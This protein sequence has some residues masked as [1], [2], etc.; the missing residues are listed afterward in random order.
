M[1]AALSF[2]DYTVIIVYLAGMILLGWWLSRRQKSDEEYFL[3][4]RG[5]PW[6]AVGV[7]VI[8]S[9]LSSLTYLSEPG[10][11]WNSGVTHVFGKMIAIPIEMLIVFFICI[12]FMMRFRFT[13][14]YEYLEHRFDYA[15][16]LLGVGLFMLM[17]VLWMG[18]VV[19]VSSKAL[20]RVAEVDVFYIIVTVGLI[21]TIYTTLG[22]LRAVIWTDVIQV[23][24][25]IGG[26]MFTI[27]FVM[28]TTGTWLP[29]W[30]AAASR[31]LVDPAV[32]QAATDAGQ[33][34]PHAVE[35]ISFSPFTR[36]TVVTAAISMCVWHVCT[37]SAN[38]M[39]VQRY[40]STSDLKT[41]RRSFVTASV[42]S[43]GLNLMLVAVGLAVLFYYYGD[44]D[45]DTTN[46]AVAA[47]GEPASPYK[48]LKNLNP[49][50]KKER[51]LIFTTFAVNRL[52][53]GLGGAVL[54]ALLAAAM[55]SID[56]GINSIATV[57]TVERKRNQKEGSQKSHVTQ[58]KIITVVAG[59]FITG[60]AYALNFLPNEWGIIDS[61]PR[62]FNAVTGPIG[63]LFMIGIFVPKATGRVAI[64]AT[65]LGLLTSIM[66]GYYAIFAGNLVDAGF[67]STEWLKSLGLATGEGK[68]R[69]LSPMLPLPC[70]LA[71]TVGSAWI[72]SWISAAQ[73]KDLAGLTWYTRHE[74]S[75]LTSDW[76]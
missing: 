29:D 23:A 39:T 40:Y 69:S 37:H 75:E 5:M 13:S 18:F 38:Q 46:V 67:L 47:N 68:V 59:V 74:K 64:M 73:T 31:H 51:D 27:F 54:A 76:Q 9:L 42:F 41:A 34:P 66:I 70:A 16:R 28:Y 60:A 72:L 49:S 1:L 8:A 35:F 20:A 21:A 44:V 43:V 2:L 24:L 53:M 25:L 7:S 52:P 11:V 6:F 65:M 10:E 71:M 32:H 14:A 57:I 12:P 19:L 33:T 4:G 45:R 26:G 15:T 48:E 62:T 36:V 61:M 3:A 22:G 50:I 56:S 30:I 58:A 55:S 17:V 63:G